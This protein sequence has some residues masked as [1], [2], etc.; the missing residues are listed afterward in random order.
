MARRPAAAKPL[1]RLPGHRSVRRQPE[2]GAVAACLFQVVA[3]DL[4]ELDQI[5][6][7]LG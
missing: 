6:S 2:L 3:E 4:V 1:P 7:V 5:T